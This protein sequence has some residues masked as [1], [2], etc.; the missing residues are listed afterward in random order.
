MRC[1]AG[2]RPDVDDDMPR[3]ASSG[4]R[5]CLGRQEE[6]ACQSRASSGRCFPLCELGEMV[7]ANLSFLPL[8]RPASFA[9]A[10]NP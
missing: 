4:W 10:T 1:D 2:T 8:P 7:A 6:F 3:L 5:I 9:M